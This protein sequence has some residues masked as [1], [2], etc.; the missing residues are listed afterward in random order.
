MTAVENVQANMNRLGALGQPFFFAFDFELS[1][2]IFSDRPLE[3]KGFL[4]S[5]PLATN[6]PDIPKPKSGDIAYIKAFP[7]PIEQYA[8]KFEIAYAGLARGDSY[9]LNLTVATPIECN[10][11]TLEIFQLADS[12]FR[13]WVPGRFVSF[14]PERFVRIQN[15]R[16]STCPMK[17]TIDAKIPEA[18][19]RILDDHK[20]TCEHATIV[21]LLR[22]DLS[23]NAEE[24]AVKRYRYVEAVVT[25]ERTILQVSSEIEG[26]LPNGWQSK[27]GDIIVSMLP[28]GSCSGAPKESTV[29]IIQRAEDGPRGYYTGVFGYFDGRDLDSAV[30][31][32]FIEETPNGLRFRSG[33]GIT[34]NSKMADEYQEMLDK[35]YLPFV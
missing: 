1:Q 35:I 33:G 9:L 25:K 10:L 18:E 16:I 6:A 21:D 20:E 27:V 26:L 2:A 8:K 4:F 23:L 7:E 13:L 12:P 3:E 5:F 22:N 17:G 19:K 24:V 28:C 30:A 31:I 34:N 29:G 14:S 32:R 11:S 15:R